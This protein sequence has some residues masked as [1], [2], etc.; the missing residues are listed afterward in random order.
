MFTCRGMQLD[1]SLPRCTLEAQTGCSAGPGSPCLG[2][3]GLAA[4][5]LQHVQVKASP[6]RVPSLK[7]LLTHP[8]R[9]CTLKPHLST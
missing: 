4:V 9:P 3:F 2:I 7:L 6:D 8:G 1:Y 5:P